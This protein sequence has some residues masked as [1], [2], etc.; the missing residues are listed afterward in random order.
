MLIRDDDPGSIGFLKP[1]YV[2]K[3]SDL[4][5]V[6]PIHRTNGSDGQTTVN[7]RT[8][9]VTAHSGTHY[10]ECQGQVT[11]E[12]GEL[13][14]DVE[15]ELL[16][17]SA[18]ECIDK[19][20]NLELSS[21]TNGAVL[22]RDKCLVRI[23]FDETASVVQFVRPAYPFLENCSFASV[24][25][26]RTRSTKGI[27]LV[28]Y[29]T[30]DITAKSGVDYRH[31]E[32]ILEFGNEETEKT[33]D[34]QIIEN[35]QLIEEG[36]TF[37]LE[38]FEPSEGTKVGRKDCSIKIIED[39]D[40]G[41][42]ELIRSAYVF[43]CGSTCEIPI[44]RSMGADGR[45][46]VPWVIEPL[47]GK[48][49]PPEAQLS[50]TVVFESMSINGAIDLFIN[51]DWSDDVSV[52]L[53][54]LQPTNN[55]RLGGIEET[56]LQILGKGQFDEVNMEIPLAEIIRGNGQSPVTVNF[57]RIIRTVNQ[58]TVVM[59]ETLDGTALE[60]KHDYYGIK[61]AIIFEPHMTQQQVQIHVNDEYDEDL[62]DIFFKLKMTPVSDHVILNNPEGEIAIVSPINE[63][64]RGNMQSRY[65]AKISFV[66]KKY[67][68]RMSERQVQ[69]EVK[70][71]G[72]EEKEVSCHLV[73]EMIE[74]DLIKTTP[75]IDQMI[76]F[77]PNVGSE[78]F[79]WDLPNIESKQVLVAL[80]LVEFSKQ[81]ME[82]SITECEVTIINDIHAGVVGFSVPEMTYR[83][84][85]L[86][87]KIDLLRAGG[88]DG[89]LDV[90]IV[91]CNQSAENGTHFDIPSP[92]EIN[93]NDGQNS[94]SFDIDFIPG[95]HGKKISR[96]FELKIQTVSGSGRVGQSTCTIHLVTDQSPCSV[97]FAKGKF[98]F[99]ANSGDQ[100][101]PLLRTGANENAAE[102]EWQLLNLPDGVDT[103]SFATSGVVVINPGSNR[104]LLKIPADLIDATVNDK[105]DISIRA[106]PGQSAVSLAEFS[107][108]TI[109]VIS[110]AE[111]GKFE[112]LKTRLVC[113]QNERIYE[114][115][116]I[117]QGG[118]DGV[119]EVKYNLKSKIDCYNGLSGSLT[120]GEGVFEQNI[121]LDINPD[122]VGDT[123][124]FTVVLSDV[125][126][127]SIGTRNEAFISVVRESKELE[128]EFSTDYISTKIGDI[129]AH[130]D[131]IV[132]GEL[133]DRVSLRFTTQPESAIPGRHYLTKSEQVLF[134]P[135]EAMKSV[136][137]G[138]LE[139]P[140]EEPVT[141]TLALLV[142]DGPGRIG[143][144]SECVINIPPAGHPGQ[145]SFTMDYMEVNQSEKAI[146]LVLSRARGTRG[147]LL[148]PWSVFSD[149]WYN[150]AAGQIMFEDGQSETIIDFPLMAQ[151]TDD[152]FHEFRVDLRKPNGQA[153]LGAMP[154]LTI[155]VNNDVPGGIVQFASEMSEIIANDG[156]TYTNLAVE[157]DGQNR[158]AFDLCYQLAPLGALADDDMAAEL[159]NSFN[160]KEII[161][162]GVRNILLNI[163]IQYLPSGETQEFYAKLI[164][165]NHGVRIGKQRLHK[166][167]IVS[168]KRKIGF[169]D[170]KVTALQS[171]REIILQVQ[172]TVSQRDNLIVP[173]MAYTSPEPVKGV[174]TFADGQE[175]DQIRIPFKQVYVSDN[176]LVESFDVEIN[177]GPDYDL[178]N[179]N[180]CQ[181][182][183]HNDLGPGVVEFRDEQVSLIQSA[184]QIALRLVRHERTMEEATVKWR[185]YAKEGSV[186]KGVV[187]TVQF[188]SGDD[189][190][191]LIIPVDQKPCDQ[192]Q[193]QFVIELEQPINAT[194]GDATKCKVTMLNDKSKYLSITS[195][196]LFYICYVIPVT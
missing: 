93:F 10:K 43:K 189:H 127:G 74:G 102:I 34:I 98:S 148:C 152:P 46:E 134:K 4:F 9:D 108:A 159:E 50:G 28:H 133:E 62:Q 145:V 191:D 183:L 121:V 8:R 63:T 132:H 193:D 24:P 146:Q 47:P 119:V 51:A 72:K 37:N 69:I 16:P 188:H 155:R 49:L 170:D 141:L 71:Q 118:S 194:L 184:G 17:D 162:A 153:E 173:W 168:Q 172:R 186:F 110:G 157:S 150:N 154:S 140:L 38:L 144:K 103:S 55:A 156:D 142:A 179:F 30:R 164:S 91:A 2:F 59:F 78:T 90:T 79:T 67:L 163:P 31:T 11:F 195:Y 87:Q 35:D 125:T 65:G 26:I 70:R 42:F 33:I 135:G 187:G 27:S 77:A 86:K 136:Q 48:T 61:K 36:R 97:S 171:N 185:I 131:I 68:C 73:S 124:T 13:S 32:G 109:S 5:A 12:D 75:D 116:V 161:P 83:V 64:L 22:D 167:R 60:E 88:T 190:L 117:R 19:S 174:L 177:P 6:V 143:P 176:P 166:V 99:L 147:A 105:F 158:T 96:S 165:S 151:P 112:F 111:H 3:E 115:P 23:L 54:L 181:V 40:P 20:F 92:L 122:M 57:N 130:I 66:Q 89:A 58:T 94:A 139:P 182:T 45:V 137:I 149:N 123:D 29:K 138:L 129:S 52:N 120:F 81:A 39:D 95:N 113:K 180:K 21:P 107:N 76:T 82:G 84:T 44:I 196:L 178:S 104:T 80:R 160:E 18:Y 192:G 106:A 1:H 101:V 53:R 7:Y 128:F 14:K 41:R 25:V 15:I 175:F 85:D 100:G 114:L 169:V 126:L 56:T